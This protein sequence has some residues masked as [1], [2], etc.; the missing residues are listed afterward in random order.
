MLSSGRT[1]RLSGKPPPRRSVAATRLLDPADGC[2][3]GSGFGGLDGHTATLRP[4]VS[5]F[6]RSDCRPGAWFYERV[7]SGRPEPATTGAPAG[8][9]SAAGR[10]SCGARKR[11]SKRS[12]DDHSG[13]AEI[14]VASPWPPVSGASTYHRSCDGRMQRSTGLKGSAAPGRPASSAIADGGGV[15]LLGRERWVLDGERGAVAGCVHAVQPRNPAVR[16]DGNEALAIARQVLQPRAGKAG[17]RDHA[18]DH[19]APRQRRELHLA[20]PDGAHMGGFDDVDAVRAERGVQLCG[21][22]H[23]EDRQRRRLGGHE[24]ELGLHACRRRLTA[25]WTAR[26]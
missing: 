5:R 18:L 10:P 6:I 11:A 13:R 15:G 20:V 9:C 2:D 23:A 19:D 25:V 1:T 14:C 16:I 3:D 26:S 8:A 12:S 17:R 4:H 7:A 24:R 21:R 22:A